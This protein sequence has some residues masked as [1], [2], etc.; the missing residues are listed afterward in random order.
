MGCVV[1]SLP[2]RKIDS[3]AC[4]FFPQPRKH[5]LPLEKEPNIK[6]SSNVS[7]THKVRPHDSFGG[8]L[9]VGQRPLE[10]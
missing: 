6:Y 5:A 1:T 4:R 7:Q 8:R 3:H 9:M 10:P 2:R